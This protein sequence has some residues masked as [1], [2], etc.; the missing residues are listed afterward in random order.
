[1]LAIDLFFFTETANN[2]VR[3]PLLLLQKADF[4]W[5]FSNKL[6]VELDGHSNLLSAFQVPYSQN[7]LTKCVL[8]AAALLIPSEEL[9]VWNMSTT[10]LGPWLLCS[11]IKFE[12]PQ[13]V[14]TF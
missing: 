3:V 13:Y 1:M 6:I 14:G 11:K 7:K 8:M 12:G 4:N 10:N 2:G 5:I 9:W